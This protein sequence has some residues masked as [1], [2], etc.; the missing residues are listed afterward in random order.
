[1]KTIMIQHGQALDSSLN[2]EL[3]VKLAWTQSRTWDSCNG[4]IVLTIR[5]TVS[6]PTGHYDEPRCSCLP[7]VSVSVYF[8][9]NS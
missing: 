5:L 9:L 4:L 1:M 3:I 7:A 6:R 8:Y 2:V